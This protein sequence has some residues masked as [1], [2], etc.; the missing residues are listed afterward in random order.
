MW[1]GQE[2]RPGFSKATVS[3]W[4]VALEARGLGAVSINVRMTSVR[5]MAVEAA[6]DG[7]PA[8]ELANGIT[9][10]KGVKSK[11]VRLGNCLSV[12]QAQ[13]LLTTPDVGTKKGLRDR[14]ILAVLLSC[15]FDGPRWL[16]LSLGTFSSGMAGGALWISWESTAEFAR[17]RCL[18]GLRWRS[19]RGPAGVA[20]AGAFRLCATSRAGPALS[21]S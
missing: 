16:H 4:R 8:P 21:P 2:P 5:R 14:A 10:V 20:E 1:Y 7:L 13:T 19:T 9:R 3:S 6:D 18:R 17:C 12:R 15:G 11:G